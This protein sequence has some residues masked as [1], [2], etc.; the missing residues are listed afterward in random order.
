MKS[1]LSVVQ[2][3]MSHLTSAEDTAN[4]GIS[5]VEN[6]LD[7]IQSSCKLMA[8]VSAANT[9]QIVGNP[10]TAMEN[11]KKIMLAT[12]DVIKQAT[13]AAHLGQQCISGCCS[14]VQKGID[15]LSDTY[16]NVKKEAGGDNSDNAKNAG[17]LCALKQSFV[18]AGSSHASTVSS[19]MLDIIAQVNEISTQSTE[20]MAKIEG[21]P[22]DI[23]GHAEAY[24]KRMA[25]FHK[26]VC[27]TCDL[28]KKNF[29]MIQKGMTEIAQKSE[30]FASSFGYSVPRAVSQARV[31]HLTQKVVAHATKLIEV[32]KKIDSMHASL[33]KAA[34]VPHVP[35]DESQT[36]SMIERHSNLLPQ[37]FDVVADL[38]AD[39]ARDSARATPSL[40]KQ[41]SNSIDDTL[42]QAD[43]LRSFSLLEIPVHPEDSGRLQADFDEI[44]AAAAK[45]P[46]KLP[47]VRA[48]TEL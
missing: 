26:D 22:K 45:L 11:M 30:T 17:A 36:R 33:D 48:L 34:P 2:T 21:E 13:Q 44:M 7:S 24:S 37:L 1:R 20:L 42:D 46:A 25:A 3:F 31:Q 16:D 23:L 43:S 4:K 27:A 19:K 8:D 40:E 12:H 14:G 10:D 29:A 35:S 32:N 41:R 39:D 18:E 38:K 5:S 9:M 47:S 15:G 28:L 6:C